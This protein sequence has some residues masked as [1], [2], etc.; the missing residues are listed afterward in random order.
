MEKG[1]LAVSLTLEGTWHVT[2]VCVFFPVIFQLF[3]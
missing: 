1:L 2:V 3:V